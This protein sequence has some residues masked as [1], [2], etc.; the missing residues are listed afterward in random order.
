MACG[1]SVPLA[2]T[3]SPRRVTSRSSWRVSR[4]PRTALAILSRTEFEPISTAAKVGMQFHQPLEWTSSAILRLMFLGGS[5]RI[6]AGEGVLQR[7]GKGLDF[8]HA[9]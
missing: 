8:D 4:R 6:Y 5:P 2:K 1:S 7:S 3:L 9:L